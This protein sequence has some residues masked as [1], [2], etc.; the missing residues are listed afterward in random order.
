ML[1]DGF[2][3]LFYEYSL[4]CIETGMLDIET[5]N[6]SLDFFSGA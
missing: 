1:R 6:A 2:G 3:V 4:N 5:S